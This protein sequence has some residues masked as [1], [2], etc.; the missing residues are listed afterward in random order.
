[1]SFITNKAICIWASKI[2]LY[3]LWYLKI[4]NT[5]DIDDETYNSEYRFRPIKLSGIFDHKNQIYVDRTRDHERGYCILTP[6]YTHVDSEGN[7]Q[8]VF[9]ERGWIDDEYKS[10]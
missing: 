8:G 9:V 2:I 3:L 1:M 6:F 5:I 10:S 4:S 7:K